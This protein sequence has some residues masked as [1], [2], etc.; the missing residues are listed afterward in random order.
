MIERPITRLF[1]WLLT[2][3]LLAGCGGSAD[4]DPS[5]R[6]G[7]RGID[8]ETDPKSRSENPSQGTQPVGL[9]EQDG[10]SRTDPES[11]P[12][13]SSHGPRPVGL[14]EDRQRIKRESQSRPQR[15][16]G[17]LLGGGDA[18]DK[19]IP[20]L[21][22]M[23]VDEARAAAAG[24]RK[25]SSKRIKLYT[26]LPASP[27]V[28]VL[29]EVFDQAFPQWCDYFGIDP[30]EHPDWRMTGFIM[31]DKKRFQ[32]ADLLPESLPP[33]EHGYCRN[34]TLWLYEQPSEYYRRHLLLHEG[35]HAF[36][37]TLLGGCGPPWY[38][39][40]I[41]ELL[42]THRWADGHLKLNY[43]PASREEVPMWGRIK[44]IKDRFAANC[45]MRLRDVVSY[46]RSAHLDTEPYAWCWAAAVLLDRHPRYRDRFRKLFKLVR[47]PDFSDR[48]YRL[49]GDHWDELSDQWQVFIVD[50]EYGSVVAR[51]AI[52][53]SPGEPLPA[54]GTDVTVA[55][56]RGWQN[57]G[58]KLEEGTAY[59]LQAS[60]RYQV[61]DQPRIW[62]CEPGGVSIRYYHGLPLGILLG[63]VRPDSAD[64]LECPLI[65]PIAIGLAS[66]LTP[67][68]TG[69]LYL[70]INDSTAE[71]HDNAG[72]LT[73]RISN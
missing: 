54:E 8:S 7:S 64:G 55:A 53:F 6:A 3:C 4:L 67:K 28:D 9:D 30:A 12:E 14:E 33:F 62:W 60:G 10:R 21:P 46:D 72:E 35:T 11:R 42:S 20:N 19:W 39:E 43:M 70:R 69:T 23:K 26:D 56:D 45:A 59:R 58:V 31:K 50:L 18:A 48:F 13:S 24:I 27:E 66:T 68:R 29:P 57:S 71:L 49:I 41:A 44:I 73:V 63:A 51:T 36:M 16:L 65:R 17:D 40:G 5:P 2:A 32:K 22:R 61:A 38:M 1:A 52:D 25:L 47:Q 15:S 37:N 34:Y